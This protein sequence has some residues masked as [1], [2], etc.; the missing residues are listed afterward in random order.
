M[1]KNASKT[2]FADIYPSLHKIF[3]VKQKCYPED[4]QITETSAQC[5][6]QNM[7]NHTLSRILVVSEDNLQSLT[8]PAQV[9]HGTLFLKAGFD[10]ASS[11]SIYKQQYHQ[12]ELD[13]VMK[14]EE[15]LFQT[16]VVPL[17][18]NI[19]DEL[20][21]VNPKPN[22]SHFCRPLRLQYKKETKELSKSEYES[23]VHEIEGLEPLKIKIS[24]EEEESVEVCINFKVDC[25]MFDGKV[26]NALTET[27]STQSCNICGAKPSE[28]NSLSKLEKKSVSDSA[29][30]LGLSTLHCWIRIFEYILHVGYKLEIKKHQVWGLH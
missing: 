25:T 28:M 12:S 18:L 14:N 22:S 8:D 6:L 4:L 19:G 1:I 10:G 24:K 20:I 13:E 3:D 23:L 2:Q 17:R 15:S 11:Q 9:L 16:A 26:V 5:S 30:D 29:C 27:L 7:V 21:W